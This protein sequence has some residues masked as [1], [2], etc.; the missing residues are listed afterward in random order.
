MYSISTLVG[1]GVAGFSG[2]GGPIAGAQ[3]SGPQGI[4]VDSAG[5]IYIADVGN[6]R[7]RKIDTSGNIN[8]VAGNGT[9][10]YAGDGA[11]ATAA[12]LN[13]PSGIALDSQGNL[14]I[15]DTVN[16]VVRKVSGGNIS[17]VAGHNAFGAGS[18]GDNGL[19][20]GAQ[21]NSP[22]AVVLDAA[23]NLYIADTGNNSV[24]KVTPGTSG[25]ITTI[26]GI[27]STAGRLNGPVALALDASGALYIA[28]KGNHRIAKWVAP[29]LTNFAGILT[30]GFSGDGG[31][32]NV[33]KLY[34]PSGVAVDAAGN[35]YIGDTT[36]G[37]IRKVTT[38]GIINTIAGTGK[39]GYTGDGGP[40]SSAALNFPTFLAVNAS[41]NIFVADTGNNCVRLI[42]AT[43]PTI[44]ANGIGN[45][46]SGAPQI[47]PGSL[48]SI[49]GT[50]FASTIIGAG[51]PYPTNLGGVTV[52]VNGQ[53]APLVAVTPGQIN[54]QVPWGTATGTATIKVSVGGGTSNAATVPVLTAA[55]GI[56]FYPDSGAAIA[57]NYD[58]SLNTSGLPDPAGTFII[59]YLT[60]GGPVDQS[61]ADG[62]GAPSNPPA[63]L[64]SSYSATIGSTSA[65]VL[66]AGMA[67]GF[68]GLVQM[69]IAVPA[70]LA[71]GTYPLTVTVN[72]VKSNS[73][74]I[75]VRP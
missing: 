20:T 71:A 1:N 72:G 62:A 31:Q 15:A 50:N 56:F 22:A 23:G 49:Y 27:G 39:P 36:N 30:P 4:A 65:Q 14:Y 45:S 24:R 75:F 29:T 68:A 58:Y 52:S 16:Q 63:N 51:A 53:L 26:V 25:V 21:L 9:A 7:I 48:A 66:F 61:I 11:A 32:A 74:N 73:A 28:D 37:R 47:S 59:A 6:S 19:A 12:E 60:G 67:P 42:S 33:S 44:S 40:A 3:L 2:D 34:N 55:P 10:G 69:N 70:D 57:E 54:F 38:D 18:S 13:K 64:T 5:N 35:V 17:T 8:T 41:G 46:A 43:Y